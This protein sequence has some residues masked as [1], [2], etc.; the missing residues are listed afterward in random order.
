MMHMIKTWLLGVILTSFAV[1]LARQIA[2]K[3]R[4]QT[5]VR[6]AGGL[7]MILAMLQPLGTADWSVAS[8]PAGGF[9]A[10]AQEQP[11]YEEQ[12]S[13][14]S[15]I[16]AEKTAAYIWD[17]A[18]TLG[19]DCGVTVSADVG[20]S[21]IPLPSLVTIHGA[22]HAGLS[23]WL[24]EEVGLPADKQIWLE[25]DEWTTSKKNER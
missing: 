13:E 14:F 11:W 24:D 23:A 22:Y 1:A 15:A 21:G 6:L 18:Q 17:K 16:I 8:V 2:P 3:G 12:L 20:E 7:V 5:M 25:E 4:Q 9:L 10:E 19:L